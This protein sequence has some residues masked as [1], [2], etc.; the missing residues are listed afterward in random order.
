MLKKFINGSI[1]VFG[2]FIMLLGLIQLDTWIGLAGFWQT[3]V[4]I[5]LVFDNK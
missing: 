4:G 5:D 2:V 3:M 1:L